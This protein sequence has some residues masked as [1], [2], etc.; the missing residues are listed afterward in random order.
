[1]AE[2]QWRFLQAKSLSINLSANEIAANQT[3][4]NAKSTLDQQRSMPERGM[5][6]L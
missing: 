1:M 3:V 5:G 4:G 6:G 2:P